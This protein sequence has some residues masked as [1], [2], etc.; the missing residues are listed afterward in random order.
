M[1]KAILEINR[2]DR[3]HMR[4]LGEKNELLRYGPVGQEKPGMLDAND[5][6]RDLSGVVDDINGAVLSDESL[7]MLRAI[8]PASIPLVESNPCTRPCVGEIE[9]FCCIVLNFSDHA[10][11]TGSKLPDNP[12]LFMKANWGYPWALTA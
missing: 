5:G 6:L 2:L 11:E 1:R 4:P 7:A 10:A 12:T 9:K 8:D 3:P